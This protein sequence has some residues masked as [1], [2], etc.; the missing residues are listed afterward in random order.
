[1]DH[2]GVSDGLGSLVKEEQLSPALWHVGE[3]NHLSSSF[4]LGGKEGVEVLGGRFDL[5]EEGLA[6]GLSFHNSSSLS[7]HD[8]SGGRA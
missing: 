6:S 5:E 3:L 2:L 4:L 1:L 8:L 7:F